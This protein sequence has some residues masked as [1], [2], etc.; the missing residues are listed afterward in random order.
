MAQEIKKTKPSAVIE[1]I[2]GHLLVD[3]NQLDIN[4]ERV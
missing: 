2:F 1:N 3:Y 4:M